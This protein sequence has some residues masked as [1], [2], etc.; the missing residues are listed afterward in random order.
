MVDANWRFELK[1][2]LLRKLLGK[3]QK[4][5]NLIYERDQKF[6]KYI[7]K[8]INNKINSNQLTFW[9]YQGSC[10]N[11]LKI[12][13][14]KGLFTIYEQAATYIGFYKQILE[15]EKRINPEWSDS[16]ES[17]IYPKDY[18]KRLYEEPYHA[19][20]IVVASDFSKQS[21]IK[22]GFNETQ[23][24]TLPLGV[25]FSNIKKRPK[26]ILKNKKLKV[27]YVGRIT[28][29]KGIKYLLESFKL[30]DKN[31]FELYLIGNIQGSGEALKEYKKIFTYIPAV[32][33]NELYNKYVEYDVL[34][35]PSI[36]EGF[37]FVIVEAL[38]SG[39]PVITTPHTMGP[40]VV[41]NDE[42]GYIVPIRDSGAIAHALEKLRNKTPEDFYAMQLNAH[43]SALQY[44]WDAFEIRLAEMLK[45]EGMR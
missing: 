39:L 27:L 20:K 19:Q 35:S 13:N 24:T 31:E 29:S 15:E 16:F 14:E 41:H 18:E 8:I 42:N 4:V 23:I 3:T 33:Q 40:E 12:A 30:L 21:L 2:I 38:A 22:S 32:S 17:L 7:S 28:Q 9:G 5:Q 6:D 25:D 11:S 44:S 45:G 34:V 10:L 43:H 36:S 1:E 26:S 37:G